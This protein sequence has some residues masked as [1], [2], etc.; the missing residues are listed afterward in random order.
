MHNARGLKN[1]RITR[2]N[3]DVGDTVVLNQSSPKTT[4]LP[5]NSPIANPGLTDRQRNFKREGALDPKDSKEGLVTEQG[6]GSNEM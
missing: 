6:S 2:K 3:V 4:I 1:T 5:E